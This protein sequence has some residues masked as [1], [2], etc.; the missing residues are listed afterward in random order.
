M[1]IDIRL[2]NSTD[3]F[4]VYNGTDPGT[5]P[6]AS[7]LLFSSNYLP[8]RVSRYSVS[9]SGGTPV[10]GSVLYGQSFSAPPLIVGGC[11]P[12]GA[13]EQDV[14]IG[15]NYPCAQSLNFHEFWIYLS[16][17]WAPWAPRRHF[18]FIGEN[19]QLKYFYF[20]DFSGTLHFAVYEP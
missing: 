3:P 11:M 7:S 20:Q 2:G 14:L 1:A 15:N 13:L 10:T 5:N 17:I 4:R 6:L 8:N 16:G 12:S 18:Y 9:V 19:D